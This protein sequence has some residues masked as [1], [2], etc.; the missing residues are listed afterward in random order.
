MVGAQPNPGVAVIARHHAFG[1]DSSE[2]EA[3]Y[4][5]TST[6]HQLGFYSNSH[7]MAWNKPI[8]ETNALPQPLPVSALPSA[9][10]SAG[11]ALAK[12]AK[13]VMGESFSHSQNLH[14][15]TEMI[16][17]GQDSVFDQVVIIKLE[18][19]FVNKHA[20]I[21]A[22][23]HLQGVKYSILHFH[24]RDLLYRRTSPVRTEPS[25]IIPFA[26]SRTD[27]YMCTD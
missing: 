19:M 26:H 14:T 18:C 17:S 8:T 9:A 12:E 11:S 4:I 7:N 15:A 1:S 6:H 25:S 13:F 27:A 21:N 16:N 5:P 3:M 23:L 10:D 2:A 22:H 20:C 24:A